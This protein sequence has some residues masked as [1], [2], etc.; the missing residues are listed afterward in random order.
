MPKRRCSTVPLPYLA[1]CATAI[2]LFATP[3]R[4]QPSFSL[5][6]APSKV[7]LNE[8]GVAGSTIT[9]QPVNG[10]DGSV[11][12]SASGLPDGVVATFKPASTTSTSTLV[13]EAGIVAQTGATTVTITGTSGSL[14]QTISVPLAVSAAIG[15]GGSGTVVDLSPSY[16]VY[17]IYTNG[18]P[19]TTGGLDGVGW[20]YSANL[21]T[22]S[23][24]YDD[25]QFNFGPANQLDAVSGTG[26]PILLPAGQ[27]TGMLM[28]ATGVEG[29]QTAQIVK[30][31]YADGT[32]QEFERS[33][34][35]WFTPQNYPDE[36]EAV[37]MPYRAMADGGLDSRGNFYLYAHYFALNSAKIVESLTISD[38]RDVVILAVTLLGQ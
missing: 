34:S 15:T 19:F 26:Q 12:L 10:F 38:N 8:H 7:Y 3:V 21:L 35:D 18:T 28:L 31:T 33:F 9:V 25:I 14:T 22:G 24:V 20:A 1:A 5:T 2:L 27:F 6:A 37:T 16:N 32:N 17:G 13:L 30:V 4:A 23:R 11:T 36:Y 29:N